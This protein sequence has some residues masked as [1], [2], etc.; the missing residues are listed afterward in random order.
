MESKM[1]ARSD[2]LS[3]AVSAVKAAVDAAKAA[4]VDA[5]TKATGSD[6]DLVAAVDA[7]L[8]VLTAS[9]ATLHSM[10]E[11]APVAPAA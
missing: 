6:P 8:P 5:L 3:A 10:T 9:V 7:A 1:S 11:P 4:L 2:A